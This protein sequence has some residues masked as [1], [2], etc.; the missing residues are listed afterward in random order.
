MA[1]GRAGGP[2][3]LPV[4]GPSPLPGSSTPAGAPCAGRSTRALKKVIV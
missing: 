3:G 1:G 4:R 2:P